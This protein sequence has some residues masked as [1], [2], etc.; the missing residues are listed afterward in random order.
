MQEQIRAAEQSDQLYKERLQGIIS[1]IE[2]REAERVAYQEEWKTQEQTMHGIEERRTEIQ[3]RLFDVQH[4]LAECS[5]KIEDGKNEMIEILN[6]RASTKGRMQRYDAMLEQIGIRKSELSQRIIKLKSEENEQTD[7]L[8]EHHKNYQE[9][10]EQIDRV[11]EQ[12]GRTEKEVSSLRR[13]LDEQ[14]KKL[15]GSQT[16]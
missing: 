7:I 13:Q 9:L 1:D 3:N 11:N 10:N 14:N 15:E 4:R 12:F 8:R 2:K 5:Q 6:R 16:S